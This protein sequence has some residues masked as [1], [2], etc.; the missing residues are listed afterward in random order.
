MSTISHEGAHPAPDRR[1]WDVRSIVP[2]VWAS[3]A[4]GVM[5]LAVSVCAV[6]G[7]DIASYT[8]DGTHTNIPSAVAVALF[9]W[10]GTRAV[11]RWGFRREREPD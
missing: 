1:R 8:N 2:E 10:L 11:A 4:I 9:A 6:W 5:W 7:P 3:L